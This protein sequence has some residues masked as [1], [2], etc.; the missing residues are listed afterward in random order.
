MR[1]FA[2]L[3]NHEWFLNCSRQHQTPHPPAAPPPKIALEYNIIPVWRRKREGMWLTTLGIAGWRRPYADYMQG[4]RDLTENVFSTNVALIFDCIWRKGGRFQPTY[5]GWLRARSYIHTH[6]H[7]Q[8]RAKRV[9]C[10]VALVVF[11]AGN[12]SCLKRER[13]LWRGH[14]PRCR[15]LCRG[16]ARGP[17]CQ[18]HRWL[19]IRKRHPFPRSVIVLSAPLKIMK[20][21]F[22]CQRRGCKWN[23]RLKNIMMKGRLRRGRHTKMTS[24]CPL[25][26]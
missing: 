21:G 2:S 4:L 10:W 11:F 20:Q 3:K 23:L 24:L 7:I 12:L 26:G 22:Y 18:R 6:I 19:R 14:S 13:R 16:L 1:V 25:K 9:K 15:C 8:R 5:R 17:T